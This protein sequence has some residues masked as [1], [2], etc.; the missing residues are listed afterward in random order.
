LNK[1]SSNLEK[2]ICSINFDRSGEALAVGTS[3]KL[4]E[5]FDVNRQ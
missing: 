1:D 2:Y 3:N 4:V 5:I